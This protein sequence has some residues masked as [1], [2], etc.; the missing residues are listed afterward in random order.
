MKKIIL[1]AFLI[2]I[3]S[4]NLVLAAT[5][6]D[7]YLNCSLKAIPSGSTAEL[8]CIDTFKLVGPPAEC[9]YPVP[10]ILPSGSTCCCEKKPTF[11]CNWKKKTYVA[12][13][14]AAG[15][16]SAGTWYGG[17]SDNE[18]G[19][20]DCDPSQE[21]ETGYYVGGSTGAVCCCPG[22][23][24]AT[25]KAKFTMPEWQVPIDGITLSQA[26]CTGPD[27]SGT[28][29]IPW[30]AQYIQGVY[31]YGLGLGGIIASLVL[32]AGGVLW[33]ISAGDASKI[34]EAKNL[35]AGSITG[36][37]ILMSSYLIL[38]QINPNLVSLKALSVKMIEKI[39][40]SDAS[41]S[42]PI[43]EKENPYQTGCN[44]AR[45]GD[46]SFCENYGSNEPTG[47]TNIPGT[48][49]RAAS[50]TVDKY[51]KAMDCV[52]QKNGGKNLFSVSSAFRSAAK[53]L[54]AKKQYGDKAATPC[55]SNH[56]KGTALDLQ[57]LDGQKMSWAHNA[58]SGL[59]T[60]MNDQGL[61]ANLNDSPDEPWHWSPSGR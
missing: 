32:M 46:Y 42:T 17:C 25:N 27:N 43:D 31:R 19:G 57:R 53:Q 2:I 45:K 1:A 34:T 55:C 18:K 41:V 6:E 40:F 49:L 35:I 51:L 28:C 59:K 56:G 26:N 22:A 16:A 9:G 11:T 37:I 15:N 33:L 61:Y 54:D 38:E 58:S 5:S 29:E 47:L 23:T 4:P 44:Y 30:I 50:S 7:E 10:T 21:P 36:L 13:S 20:K 60:C 8:T 14:T 3:L 52:K 12:G 39:E 24:P 48:A